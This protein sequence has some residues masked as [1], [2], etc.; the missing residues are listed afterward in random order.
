M[1]FTE[2]LLS[3]G[4]TCYITPSLR[5]FGTG[6]PPF[7]LFQGLCLWCLWS[8]SPFF[9]VARFSRWLLSNCFCFFLLKGAH[10]EWFH[11]KVPVGPDVSPSSFF[12]NQYEQKFQVV[13][14]PT[15][16]V[17]KLQ[18]VSSFVWVGA[19]SA[20]TFWHSFFESWQKT[21]LL[22]LWSPALGSPWSSC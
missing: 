17:L 15:C 13:S 19:D 7:L 14:G 10:P 4:S 16:L 6:I 9:H 12:S 2:S 5:L 11:H 18:V 22:S 20:I 3:N 21:Q 1:L 8:V